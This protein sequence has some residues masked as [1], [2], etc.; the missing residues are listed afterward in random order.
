MKGVK[1]V[2]EDIEVKLPY[3]IRRGDEDIAAAA[4]DVWPGTRRF[5]TTPSRSESKEDG[6]R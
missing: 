3:D 1:A 4:V 5:P 6:S 2:A